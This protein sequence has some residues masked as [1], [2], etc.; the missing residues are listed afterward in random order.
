MFIGLVSYPIY[1]EYINL[2][3]TQCKKLNMVDTQKIFRRHYLLDPQIF[4]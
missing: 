4:F 3:D 1:D 2:Y